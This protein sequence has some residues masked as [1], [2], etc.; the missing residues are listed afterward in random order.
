MS[1]RRRSWQD[2]RVSRSRLKSMEQPLNPVPLAFT[3]E[4]VDIPEWELPGDS[5]EQNISL[6]KS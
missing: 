4:Q 5:V 6:G 2:H 3:G 1:W